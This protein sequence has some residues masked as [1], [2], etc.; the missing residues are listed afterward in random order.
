VL[1]RNC[2]GS[3]VAPNAKH[4]ILADFAADLG[5]KPDDGAALQLNAVRHWNGK[6]KLT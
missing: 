6:E 4:T 1:R 3:A 2:E 5:K